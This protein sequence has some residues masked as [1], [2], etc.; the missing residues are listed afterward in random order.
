MKKIF[1]KTN[2]EILIYFLIIFFTGFSCLSGSCL[3][4]S[5]FDIKINFST[6]LLW[7]VISILV[8]SAASAVFV[9]KLI[10]TDSGI[11]V[12]PVLLLFLDPLFRN[13]FTISSY[14]PLLV[15]EF[16][17]IFYLAAGKSVSVKL[18]LTALFAF[19]SSLVFFTAAYS[20]VPLVFCVYLLSVITEE[21]KNIKSISNKNKQNKLKDKAKSKKQKSTVNA[22]EL[23]S[24]IIIAVTVIAVMLNRR[25][26]QQ[27][28][29]LYYPKTY[30]TEIRTVH[31]WVRLLLPSFPYVFILFV[32]IGEYL[33]DKFKEKKFT[34]SSVFR[35]AGFIF[36]IVAFYVVIL[37]GIFKMNSFESYSLVNLIVPLTLIFVY[38]KDKVPAGK[39]LKEIYAWINEHKAITAVVTV[40]WIVVTQFLFY[41]SQNTLWGEILSIA[42]RLL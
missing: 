22:G 23:L 31:D 7:S 17:L 35:K 29:Q 1:N 2:G 24:L 13:T 12:L 33:T 37:F 25:F 27:I 34:L 15:V 32:F 14:L 42:G 36:G 41:S 18:I 21:N 38:L 16:V 26:S 19:A 11:L 30:N 6:E 28:A 20:Y 9:Q 40:V 8:F 3:D 4:I 10:A 39:A 5:T